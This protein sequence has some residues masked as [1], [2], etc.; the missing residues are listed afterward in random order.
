MYNFGVL[1]RSKKC[2][3]SLFGGQICQSMYWKYVDN[4]FGVGNNSLSGQPCATPTV[5]PRVHLAGRYRTTY[6]NAYTRLWLSLSANIPAQF[7]EFVEI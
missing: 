4:I 6:L 2:F 1:G 7:C 3:R 5:A